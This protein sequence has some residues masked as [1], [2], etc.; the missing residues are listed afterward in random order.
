[1]STWT[2][3][4]CN[5]PDLIN[6]LFEI[7]NKYVIISAGKVSNNIEL[8]FKKYM[9]LEL[10]LCVAVGKPNTYQSVQEKN[11]WTVIDSSLYSNPKLHKT[12]YK[13]IFLLLSNV[14]LNHSPNFFV[15]LSVKTGLQKF[16]DTILYTVI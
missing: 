14:Q 2:T 7:N 9:Y 13:D 1:M 5:D 16:C 10:G 8:V 11:Y 3:N 6:T 15:A 12:L 4:I